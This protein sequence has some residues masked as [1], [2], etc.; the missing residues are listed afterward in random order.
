M[1]NMRT[2][3]NCER[4]QSVEREDLGLVGHVERTT[5]CEGIEKVCVWVITEE[6]EK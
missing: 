5:M 3:G 6:K 2:T 1:R 4:R